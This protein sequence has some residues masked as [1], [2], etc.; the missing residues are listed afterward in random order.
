MTIEDL[1]QKMKDGEG[2]VV[3]DKTFTPRTFDVL[4]LETGEKM[5][6]MRD[7][8]HAWLSIDEESEEVML[9]N[10]VE[11]EIDLM[12]E[13]VFHAGDDYELTFEAV[14]KVIDEDGV[15]EDTV[16]F[17]DYARGDGQVLRALEYEV[18]SEIITLLGWTVSEE[19]IR[20]S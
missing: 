5:Y 18:N 14:A 19:E 10:E 13:S 20:N 17:K 4:Q 15:E 8:T 3:R 11:A 12:Q 1:L 16:T 9:F 2:V 6:L 7:E